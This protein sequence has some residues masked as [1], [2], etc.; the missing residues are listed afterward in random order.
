M[1]SE[2]RL[3]GGPLEATLRAQ[4]LA[5]RLTLSRTQ[6]TNLILTVRDNT[7]LELTSNLAGII[8]EDTVL[9]WSGYT[10]TPRKTQTG[11]GTGAPT[12][13]LTCLSTP[14]QK[15]KDQTGG[16]SWGNHLVSPWARLMINDAGA[17]WLVQPDL[18]TQEI[19][20]K[21]PEGNNATP[22][23]TWDV[24]A[25]QAKKVGAW[26]FEDGN[27]IVFAKPS[28]LAAQ[29]DTRRF[30]VQ[31]NTWTDHTKALTAA[32]QYTIDYDQ[33]PWEGREQLVLELIDPTDDQSIA[34][35]ARPG[36][37]LHYTGNAAPL[38]P[39]WLVT[40][41]DLPQHWTQPT[42]ITAW[43]P[44]D[45]PEILDDPDSASSGGSSAGVPTGPIGAGGWTG[46][47]LVNATEIVKEGQRRE[48]PEIAYTMAIMTAMVESSL[49]NTPEGDADDGV[50]NPDGTPT[51][52]VGLFQ[53]QDPWGS[54]SDRM[55]P[56]KSAGLFYDRLV[57]LDG[58]ETAS[59]AQEAGTYCQTVQGSAY[60]DKY[61]TFYGD[62]RL[63]VKACIEAGRSG[64]G[65]ESK[66]PGELGKKI[67]RL[68]A[69]YE[70]QYID[71]DAAF[72]AQC[73]DLAQKYLTDLTGIGMITA[74]GKDFW[75]HPQLLPKFTPIP[76]DQ[77]PRKGDISSWGAG[78]LGG[79]YGH[80]AIY[81]HTENGID[82]H[83]SQNPGPSRTQPLPRSGLQG[84]MRPKG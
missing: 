22:E 57:T 2:V 32:P 3:N 81:S 65:S 24:M 44:V 66:A 47:Q 50:T 63:V 39:L 11:G 45:P 1:I 33:K 72:G 51:T 34:R 18:G 20:R 31:W 10:F 43:R 60:P 56:S 7:A 76:K 40:Q 27:R 59:N 28:W 74:N 25:E 9:E 19:E 42:R 29:P 49:I 37:I 62:A 30:E 35:Q 61:A 75:N 68:M 5:A 52:S 23:S 71:V 46:E 6:I 12:V 67:D 78:S 84:W 36:D 58:Y 64:E 13:T 73:Y 69:S 4:I 38:N 41:V 83:V 14:V 79:V 53:Q 70:G 17:D 48:L 82:H 54:R 26:L 55:T 15:L 16:K 21:E 77:K 80:V 8:T